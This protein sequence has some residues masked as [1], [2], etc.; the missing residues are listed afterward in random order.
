M[1]PLAPKAGPVR[2]PDGTNINYLPIG[3][4]KNVD[5]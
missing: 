5:I 3:V 4:G 2:S 1:L